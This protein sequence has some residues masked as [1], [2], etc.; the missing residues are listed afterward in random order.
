[1]FTL[2]GHGSERVQLRGDVCA[3][4]DGHGRPL[5]FVFTLESPRWAGI[6]VVFAITGKDDLWAIT[7]HR[8]EEGIPFHYP[9]TV[10]SVESETP[11]TPGYSSAID[12]GFPEDARIAVFVETRHAAW[13]W[14][15]I[16]TWTG[17]LWVV[18]N[19]SYA[20]I[21][22]LPADPNKRVDFVSMLD[23]AL[24]FQAMS[25][26]SLATLAQAHDGKNAARVVDHRGM[27]WGLGP[28]Y[29]HV[30]DAGKL[31]RAICGWSADANAPVDH[32]GLTLVRE[33]DPDG[34]DTVHVLTTSFRDDAPA[35]AQ[36]RDDR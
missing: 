31:P 3:D 33:W 11:D 15:K 1:M 2:Q 26:K 35:L 28:S 16:G 10:R 12:V 8:V 13:R 19:E 20:Q 21:L 36:E 30:Y 34:G 23:M 9:I 7:T 5:R 17:S 29:V 18:E 27:R 22:P 14:T 25:R 4:I 24:H 32:E 6:E